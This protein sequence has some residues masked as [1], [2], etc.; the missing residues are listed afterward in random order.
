MEPAGQTDNPQTSGG[1]M[2]ELFRGHGWCVLAA[3]LAT[4]AVEVGTA[5]FAW[6][7][8]VPAARA[9]VA[10]LAVAVLWVA[11]TAG[12]L[13]AGADTALRSVLRGGAVVDASIP[14]LILLAAV[15]PVTALGA[16]KVYCILAAVALWSVALVRI[17]RT[18]WGR[19]ALGTAAG[20]VLFV[21]LTSPLW[22]GGLLGA[23]DGA[24]RRNIV[25]LAVAAN[26]F[27]AVATATVESTGFVWH[28][29][30]L[31]YSLTP[32]GDHVAAPS[33][34]WYATVV[35][36]AGLGAIFAGIALLR[37]GKSAAE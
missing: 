3:A 30:P 8:D 34:P 4:I 33:P 24:A 11:M 10:T 18:P 2:R 26:P 15:G 23:A 29:A 13:S 16:V 12:P 21:M 17:A 31:M 7:V 5:A 25:W 6:R 14:A 19:H 20:V 35:I 27:Y 37:G 36:Y 22:T 9:A 28:Q 1:W 32:I